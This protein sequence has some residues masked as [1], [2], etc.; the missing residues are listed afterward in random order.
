M[1]NKQN[2]SYT[3]NSQPMLTSGSLKEKQQK[4]ERTLVKS[5]TKELNQGNQQ[6]SFNYNNISFTNENGE[7]SDKHKEQRVSLKFLY[8]NNFVSST[9]DDLC[10]HYI[11]SCWKQYTVIKQ[12]KESKEGRK[13]EHKR[14]FRPNQ[15]PIQ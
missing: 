1:G 11:Q 9:F 13:K 14:S 15:N 3:I 4:N 12:R 8:K 10:A 2:N 6:L 5:Q 7:D